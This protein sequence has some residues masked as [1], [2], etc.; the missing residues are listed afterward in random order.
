MPDGADYPSGHELNSRLLH[1]L[2]G[3]PELAGVVR[4]NTRV[5][6]ISRQGLLKHDH[7]GSPA[8]VDAP[9]R[10]LL[11][12]AGGRER[13]EHAELVLD[14]TGSYPQANTV[15]DGGIPAP[16]E[17]E[18]A[19]H[20]VGHIPDLDTDR[21]AWAGRVTLLVGAGTSAQTAARDLAALVGTAAGT[22]LVW[23]VRAQAP[24]WGEVADDRLPGRQELVAL[25]QRLHGGNLARVRVRTGVTVEQPR[26]VAGSGQQVGITLRSTDGHLEDVVADRVL[27][28]TGSVGDT[29]LYRQLQVHECY[30]TAAPMNLSAALLAAA[31]DGPAD[32]LTQPCLG[33]DVLRVPEPNFFVLGIKS[34][35]RKPTFLLRVGYEQVDQV[36]DAYTPPTTEPPTTEPS[37]PELAPAHP[38]AS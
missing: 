9:F 11:R 31:A 16:G 36:I 10:L 33:V 28:L 20:I 30:A 34:Y 35:G 8:R 38:A 1:P 25:A 22:Q 29:S 6:G 32:C 2:A 21:D 19:E 14:A 26:P 3:L 12:E 27:A 5:L 17:H 15:G 18:L 7:I 4:T 37:T 13:I 23:A 24:E